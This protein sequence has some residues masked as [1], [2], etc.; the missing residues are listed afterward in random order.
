M[1]YRVILVDDEDIEREAMASL[2]P[3][4]QIHMELADMAWNG[5]EALEKIRM[6]VPDIVVTDIKMPVMDGIELIRRAIA[7]F[8]EMSFVVLSG[9]GEYEYTSK[10]ME[11]G[12]R[13]YIL[14]PCDEEK[15]VEVLQAAAGELAEKRAK[16]SS[17]MEFQRT[18]Q[19]T[20]P[21]A[22]EQILNALLAMDPLSKSDEILLERFTRDLGQKCVLL[23]VSVSI[24]LDPLDQFVIRNILTELIGKEQ[25]FMSTVRKREV[26]FL[27]SA[28][29]SESL[30]TLMG[31]VHKEFYKYKNQKLRSAVSR[32]GSVQESFVMYE[33]AKELLRWGERDLRQ[34]FF[35]YE[36]SALPEGAASAVDYARV[37][38]ASTYDELLFELYVSYVK[39]QLSGFLLDGMRR[40]FFGMLEFLCGEEPRGLEEIKTEWELLKAVVERATADRFP[41]GDK[42]QQRMRQILLIL[43]QN[44]RNPELSLQFLAR[45][46]LFMNEDYLG[47]LF[48]QNR[49]Q[50]YSAYLLQIR[51][52][53][54][55]RILDYNPDIRI[56][57]LAVQVGYA[58]DGQYFA[59]VFK[60]HTGMA[61]SDYRRDRLEQ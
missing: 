37:R 2:I 5:I 33:Q 17:E 42:E 39:M 40:A 34:E 36:S 22:K 59:K 10:A 53:L 11:L 13:H 23:V 55:K 56:S 18:L 3:W 52:E 25:I 49:K 32:P 6:Q 29:H 43:Y 19:R 15:M 50:R 57:D 24:D 46:I 47:R 41:K 61:P 20:L 30:G 28:A 51:M 9:Y 38:Q 60:K 16:R 4:E 48:Y 26:I 12:I 7:E 54:A 35:S 1:K 31:K 14:K 21:L 44:I 27:I 58:P 45:E 8:P